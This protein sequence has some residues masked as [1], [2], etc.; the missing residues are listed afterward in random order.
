MTPKITQSTTKGIS[1][2][3]SF[4][5]FIKKYGVVGLALGVV[6]GNAVKT[7]VDSFVNNIISPLL[8]KIIQQGSLTNWVVWDIHIGSFIND[9]INFLILL[10]I[11]YLSITLIIGRFL[12]ED[13][14]KQLKID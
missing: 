3:K 1:F 12:T 10:F 13:E 5:Q 2:I 7:L 6:I 8:G 14:K 11:V 9:L 4:I